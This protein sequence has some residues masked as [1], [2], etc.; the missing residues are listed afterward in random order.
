M[1]STTDDVEAGQPSLRTPPVPE[2]AFAML[3]NLL[4][5]ISNASEFKRRLRGL[6]TALT[7]VD[8]GQARLEADRGAFKDHEARTRAEMEQER[9]DI[10]R[11]RVDFHVA[12][13]DLHNREAALAT[14]LAALRRSDE[15]LKRRAL[16]LNNI[17][18]NALQSTPSWPQIIAELAEASQPEQFELETSRPEGLP[19]QSTLAQSFYRRKPTRRVTAEAS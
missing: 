14:D 6:H 5:A 9:A 2:A 17:E 10:E 18:L 13:A 7:A 12:E 3:E 4:A 16:L 15:T 8:E 11:R 1:D 19:A